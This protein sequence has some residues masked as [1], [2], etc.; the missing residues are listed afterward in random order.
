M[1][2]IANVYCIDTN[3]KDN[4]KSVSFSVVADN[5]KDAIYVAT[6]CTYNGKLIK[7]ENIVTVRTVATRV[8]T[9][10]YNDECKDLNPNYVAPP[11][12]DKAGENKQESK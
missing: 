8:V 12:N 10:Y 9:S 5:P 3:I 1:N 7:D 4:G 11:K 2:N 6:E